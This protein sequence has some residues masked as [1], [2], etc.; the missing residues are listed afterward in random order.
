MRSGTTTANSSKR[1]QYKASRSCYD[2]MLL[3]V[4]AF[5]ELCKGCSNYRVLIPKIKPQ[6]SMGR[7]FRCKSPTPNGILMPKDFPVHRNKRTIQDQ[8]NLGK[9]T[10]DYVTKVSVS[11]KKHKVKKA[12][13]EKVLMEKELSIS[14]MKL[15]HYE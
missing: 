15:T 9:E 6:Q 14:Q 8:R 3:E 5:N 13:L 2:A 11:R 1:L 4:K 12:D 7:T 10:N